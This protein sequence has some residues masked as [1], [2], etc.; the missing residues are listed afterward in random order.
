[1]V[2]DFLPITSIIDRFP[3]FAPEGTIWGI[4]DIHG[5]PM[6]IDT[7]FHTSTIN[8]VHQGDL[9]EGATAIFDVSA[10]VVEANLQIVYIPGMQAWAQ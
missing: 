10:H 9:E 8:Y 2:S 5:I 1:M 7:G 4:Q 3:I 6:E